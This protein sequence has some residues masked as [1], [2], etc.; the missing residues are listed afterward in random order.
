MTD[1]E[2]RKLSRKDL[3]ELLVS[4]GRERDALQAE[5]EKVKAALA[6]KQLCIE[7]SGSLAEAALQVNGV[8]YAAQEAAEQYLENIRLRSEQID[9][10]CAQR[11]KESKEKAERQLQ[12]AARMA[13]QMEEDT[14]RRCQEMENTAKEKAET[15]WAEVSTR[16]QIFYQ[17]HKELKKLLF[18]GGER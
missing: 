6:D 11:E 9:A 10:V 13:C 8:F 1:Q 16:L 2:L 17:E 4:Q 15:Y 18:D 7:Q 5:L 3:L 14:K 12:E